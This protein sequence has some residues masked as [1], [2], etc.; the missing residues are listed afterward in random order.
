MLRKKKG[1]GIYYRRSVHRGDDVAV[2]G[3]KS[4][5]RKGRKR[6]RDL[7]TREESFDRK[8]TFS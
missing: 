6:K 8:E 7:L 5:R 2:E 4:F 1:K 3:E